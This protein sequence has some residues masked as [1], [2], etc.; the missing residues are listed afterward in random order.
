MAGDEN[1]I[2]IIIDAAETKS[3][4][5]SATE[6]NQRLS[7]FR[8]ALDAF[9]NGVGDLNKTIE[10]N[11]TTVANFNTFLQD[12]STKLNDNLSKMQESVIKDFEP[13]LEKNLENM[14]ARAINKVEAK[15]SAPGKESRSRSEPKAGAGAPASN[16]A[17]VAQ[18]KGHEKPDA[19]MRETIDSVRKRVIDP[20]TGAVQ[21]VTTQTTKTT[22][23]R[24]ERYQEEIDGEI[25]NVERKIND[26]VHSVSKI[27]SITDALNKT[28]FTDNPVEQ[29]LEDINKKW[30]ATDPD[31][32]DFAGSI[33]DAIE[34]SRDEH[35]WASPMDQ[36]S[37][38][39]QKPIENIYGSGTGYGK[40]V[41]EKGEKKSNNWADPSNMMRR[42]ITGALIALH[43]MKVVAGNS[44]VAA[45][46][47]NMISNAVGH[48]LNVV[49]VPMIPAF[50]MFAQ[51]IHQ[52]ANVIN[53]M[54]YGI[55]IL[56]GGLVMWKAA[57]VLI[58]SMPIRDFTSGIRDMRAA[59]SGSGDTLRRFG[60]VIKGLLSFMNSGLGQGRLQGL[61]EWVGGKIRG[62]RA[63]GGPVWGNG[64]YVVGEKGPE[65]FVPEN[66]GVVI[67]N[68]LVD[69]IP[70]VAKRETGGT[71][72]PP[73]D[74]YAGILNDPMN[75]PFGTLG[76]G[77]AG[78]GLG[79]ALGG[80]VGAVIGGLAG[81]AMGTSGIMTAITGV[82]SSEV[83]QNVIA[84]MNMVSGVISS[85]L[86]PIAPVMGILSTALG[87]VTGLRSGR[88]GG[89]GAVSDA[90]TITKVG[91]QI[92][93][94][95]QASSF[96]QQSLT[97]SI[98]RS[99]N[100]ILMLIL[101]KLGAAAGIAIPGLA[102]LGDLLKDL[103]KWLED[104][105]AK[106]TEAWEELK[107][108][109][110]EAWEELK[111]KLK[112]AWEDLKTKL[113][114]AWEELKSKLRESWDELKTKLS[115]AW[116]ELKTK[117]SE[118][119]EDLKSKLTEKWDDLKTKLGE[120]WES[121]KSKLSE[122]WNE[123]KDK[124]PKSWEELK[125]KLGEA[126][127]DLK[128]KLTEAWADL[129]RILG[130]TLS[131]KLSA[132]IKGIIDRVEFAKDIINNAK[133]WA[134]K[135]I[136][137]VVEWAASV[138][139]YVKE[140]SI[141]GIVDLV[142]WGKTVVDSVKEKFITGVVDKI[143]FAKDI[144][145]NAKEWAVKGVIGLV[146]WAKNIVDNV[147]EKII[148][149][150]VDRIKLAATYINEVEDIIVKAIVEKIEKGKTFIN[151]VK[152]FVVKAVVEKISK[153]AN[154]INEVKDIVVK[155]VVEKIEKATN[156]IS[157]VKDITIKAI[158]EKIEK[159]KNFVSDVKDITITATVDKISVLPE[160]IT[161]FISDLKAK[162]TGASVDIDP[163]LKE[164][165]GGVLAWVKS[166][167]SSKGTPILDIIPE[168]PASFTWGEM[169]KDV[170]KGSLTSNIAAVLALALEEVA[171]T[172]TINVTDFLI[173]LGIGVVTFAA[174]EKIVV[175]LVTQ[176]GGAAAGGAAATAIAVFAEILGAALVTAVAIKF[177]YDWGAAVGNAL[178][179]GDWSNLNFNGNFI[180]EWAEDAG[181]AVGEAL[182]KL[183]S[184][185]NL[186]LN[187]AGLGGLFATL[188]DISVMLNPS[189][190]LTEKM[191]AF[192][193]AFS[194]TV[195]G[196]IPVDVKMDV[197][198]MTQT[199]KSIASTV[200][201]DG[202]YT[203][204]P[205]GS[206]QPLGTNPVDPTG[207]PIQGPLKPDGSFALGG[208][209]A[210]GGL[211]LVG[212]K[213]PELFAPD[214]GG[215][216]I[217]NNKIGGG[218]GSNVTNNFTFNVTANNPRELT[219][220]VMR[221]LK[222]ELARVK[223]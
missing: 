207:K 60:E 74:P 184:E 170:A 128:T 108:R 70:G 27:G 183:K 120:A 166:F 161:S 73:T 104:L 185:I 61:A 12:F 47:F 4:A 99:S 91:N 137:N 197:E 206:T 72:T 63:G 101:L 106:L 195:A 179:S 9:K 202:T 155:A 204:N 17:T 209:V 110:S 100:K 215:Q 37:K 190:T 139:D 29:Y 216:I 124:L 25:V 147:K 186:A 219:E 54:P 28:K 80:G 142:E 146:E 46:G 131:E 8:K 168:L 134:I 123:L 16:V 95:E 208:P 218:G 129:K 114:E 11:T 165:T 49:L 36:F 6:A 212:E 48:L 103:G 64:A 78:A 31:L 157:D 86:A 87:V 34:K 196:G 94:T 56:I 59:L 144:I 162:L 222:M 189:S 26:V 178:N 76:G 187:N 125:S 151:E 53:S 96:A 38:T 217:P 136:V 45:S 40:P 199:I 92:V 105:K 140:K 67:P 68:K 111:T 119:W 88:G 42:E 79:Y 121:L 211:Y 32:P 71:V 7:E 52:V 10:T 223:M 148:T 154:F 203:Y 213:G 158:A 201:G 98:A 210:A 130:E 5:K 90:P 116:D 172:G 194:R 21:E 13:R 156:F 192:N 149:G 169:F 150:V 112:E 19:V 33:S 58:A 2:E 145:N 22:T 181:R 174:A 41:K 160:K 65:I 191:D 143:E 51:L 62:K 83:G 122:A 3:A 107:R 69:Q 138:I 93:K 159:G 77:I 14:V 205:T 221:E 113:R 193:S 85:A 126:W 20:L 39:M 30:K 35:T 109:F 75:D 89:G 182:A 24:V 198:S 43:V 188:G 97:S 214:V 127:T 23:T 163:K 18:P 15:T 175:A 50:Q 44:Q 66:S 55:R 153:A 102:G 176:I 171:R 57:S 180:L 177:A 167:F 135:G 152:D 81:G 141:K 132:L 164:P 1:R 115:E 220:T 82:V 84:T 133:E 118:A 117:L 173:K 200:N